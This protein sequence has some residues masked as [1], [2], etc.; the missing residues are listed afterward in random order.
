MKRVSLN[1]PADMTNETQFIDF[2]SVPHLWQLLQPWINQFH[3]RNHWNRIFIFRRQ[4]KILRLATS[5]DWKSALTARVVFRCRRQ[6]FVISFL[7]RQGKSKADWNFKPA[8]FFIASHK[9]KASH[10]HVTKE[11]CS[12]PEIFIHH[13]SRLL[14]EW[15]SHLWFCFYCRIWIKP[16]TIASIVAWR[17]NFFKTRK[18]L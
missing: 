6:P 10:L 13:I 4:P 5:A 14:S 7:V 18:R 9:D 17:T 12:K 11:L 2:H 3:S 16:E 1:R 15:F 8:V